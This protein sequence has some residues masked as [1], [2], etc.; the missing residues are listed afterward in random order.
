MNTISTRSEVA[1]TMTHHDRMNMVLQFYGL[2]RTVVAGS[3]P[4]QPTRSKMFQIDQK[5]EASK[6]QVLDRVVIDGIFITLNMRHSTKIRQQRSARRTAML[7]MADGMATMT[8][9]CVNTPVD[10][11]PGLD[12]R[13]KPSFGAAGKCRGGFA[14]ECFGN[15]GIK[16]CRSRLRGFSSE[17]VDRSSDAAKCLWLSRADQM[18]MKGSNLT[19]KSGM[20]PTKGRCFAYQ[21]ISDF[22]R[23]SIIK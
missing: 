20:S 9:G 3:R 1:P 13:L 4:C 12:G 8:W 5:D 6:I 16:T 19:S 11:Q 10:G 21:P 23:S 7:R 14:S 15:K 22:L 17:S 2:T 18:L